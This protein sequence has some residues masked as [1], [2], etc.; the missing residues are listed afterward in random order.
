MPVDKMIVDAMLGTFRNMLQECRNK[1]FSGDD[2]EAM[3][4]VLARMEQLGV[5][6]DDTGAY[7]G[8]L[9]QE[10]LFMK[11]S[12]HYSKVLSA[13]AQQAG[14]ANSGVYDEAA[15]KQLLQNTLN[16]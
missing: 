4:S 10:G 3:A 5:E 2:L 16:A 11:F 1:N 13:A 6:M 7:S 8:M 9:V 12:D 15:D 14:S